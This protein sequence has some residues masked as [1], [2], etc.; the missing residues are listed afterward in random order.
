MTTAL[1]TCFGTVVGLAGAVL[2]LIYVVIPI[3]AHAGSFVCRL[4]RFVFQELRDILLIPIALF[5]GVIKLLRATLCVVIARWDIVHKEMNAAKLRFTEVYERTIA[6]FIENPLRTINIESKTPTNK[7]TP[8]S[9]IKNAI[10][11]HKQTAKGFTKT[12]DVFEGYKITGTLPP[13][14]SGA[15]IYIAS[16]TNNNTIVVI[17]NFAIGSGSQLPQIVRESRAMESAKKLGLVIK[18][19]LDNERFWYAMPYHAGDH[20]GVVTSNLHGKSK[21]LTTKQLQTVLCYQQTLLHT[22]KE[23][24]SAG[25]WHKDVKPEN[26]IIHDGA[27]HLVDLGLVTPLASAMTLTTHGTE[28]FRDPE[29]VR[30]AMRGVKVH[31]VDGSKFDVFGAGAVL[32]F[33]LE[34]TFPAHGG[35]SS[36]SKESPE[37]IRWIIRRAMADYDKRYNSIDE[38][39]LDVEKVLCAKDVAAFLTADLPSLGGDSPK[40]STRR[41]PTPQ[42]HSASSGTTPSTGGGPFGSTKTHGY[43]SK[44]MGIL[45]VLASIL[46]G[47]YVV[48]DSDIV[49]P[50]NES[51]PIKMVAFQVPTGRILVLNDLPNSSTSDARKT[52]SNKIAELGVAGWDLFVDAEKEANVRSWLPSDLGSTPVPVGKLEAENVTGILLIKNGENA[53]YSMYYV[54]QNGL[55]MLP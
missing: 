48:S 52:A 25:L 3:I 31:Q 5:I 2:L 30:Q 35:L 49:E 55:S 24:H 45:V 15:K 44:P 34:N 20:L 41:S 21:K 40:V 28:Y 39:L 23:Y 14:G 9:A 16:S 47:V 17:K 36:F 37:S 1:F 12:Q 32:Y 19:H 10:G 46:V 51:T 33:M 54:D 26:I 29:L 27:A 13:G 42:T 11:Q 38:M 53:T 18:H 22:L 50:V 43:K 6:V 7:Q 8:Q 4:I